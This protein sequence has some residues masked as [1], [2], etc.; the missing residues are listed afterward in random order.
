E[1]NSNDLANKDIADKLSILNKKS[2]IKVNHLIKDYYNIEKNHF[3]ANKRENDIFEFLYDD[4]FPFNPYI[5]NINEENVKTYS[6][7]YDI[8]ESDEELLELLLKKGINFNV[9]LENDPSYQEQYNR[10]IEMKQK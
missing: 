5:Y 10:Y 6:E 3:N 9:F 8:V 1:L 4:I 7:N 2:S